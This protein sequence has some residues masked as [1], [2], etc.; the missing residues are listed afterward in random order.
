MNTK[1]VFASLAAL[2]VAAPAFA[3]DAPVM[4]QSGPRI[5][6]RAGWDHDVF[7]GEGDSLSRSGVDYGTE[8]GY[9]WVGH[10]VV[11]GG[12]AG[13]EGSSAKYCFDGDCA[14]AGRN[15]T[16]GVRVGVPMGRGLVYAK[17]GYS[18]GRL[19]ATEDGDLV[20][21]ENFDGWH[22]GA[23]YE[24]N[25][26]RHTYAKLEYVYT[27]YSTRNDDVDFG[28]IDYHRHQIVAGVGVRF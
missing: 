2:V 4:M 14:K 19:R 10:G 16:A 11:L 20:A 23:G 17:G 27:N 1:F 6:A 8:L 26:T 7:S 21:G 22:L 13:I 12:Y 9:D 15:I 18:N 28:D 3:Q 5:E 25:I 24:M